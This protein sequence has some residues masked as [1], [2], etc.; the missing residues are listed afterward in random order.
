MNKQM[1]IVKFYFHDPNTNSDSM[2][3]YK[4]SQFDEAIRQYHLEFPIDSTRPSVFRVG[5]EHLQENVV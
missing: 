3:E 4:V 2:R 5:V 1:D